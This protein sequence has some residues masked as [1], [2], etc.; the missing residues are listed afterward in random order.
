MATLFE[1]MAANEIDK[2]PHN[3]HTRKK[4]NKENKKKIEEENE[5]LDFS[6]KDMTTLRKPEEISR[7]QKTLQ[8]RENKK[9]AKERTK[10]REKEIYEEELAL[11]DA[12]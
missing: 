11:L 4:V 12:E 2:N 1:E 7:Y 5:L 10:Q 3:S 6:I 8:Y 9:R